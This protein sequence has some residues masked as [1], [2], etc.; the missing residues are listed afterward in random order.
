[1]PTGVGLH[2]D[3]MA[4]RPPT[5]RRRARPGSLERPVNAR[6]YRGT[7]LVLSIPL[8]LAAF[9]VARPAP[10]PPAFPPAFD[11]A[12]AATLAEELARFHPMR[13]PGSTGATAAST[14]YRSQLQPYGL[15]VRAQP[16]TADVPGSG[17]LRFENLIATVRGRSDRRIV[18]LAHR[19]NLGIGPGAN[20]NASGTAALIVLARS[21][22]A[23][24]TSEDQQPGPAHT[25]AFVSTD[26]GALGGY[27]ARH[28]AE[29][30][31]A[32]VD[33]VINLDAIAG[34]G[35]PRLVLAG[36]RPR[37][38]ALA[39][40]R[41]ASAR[42][43][44]QTGR[45]PT[46]PSAAG[47]LIDLAFPFSLYEQAPFVGRDVSALTITTQGETP[48]PAELDT[49]VRLR[50]LLRGPRLGQLGRS[51]QTLIGSIDQG[52]EVT[53]PGP[54]Y[55]YFGTRAVRG[56]AVQLVLVAALLPFLA[57][58]V[59]LFA[60]CRRRRIPLRPAVR[61]YVS[62]LAFWLFV[63]VVFAIVAR[64][65]GWP[66][67]EPVPLPPELDTSSPWPVAAIIVLV[68]SGGGAWVVA[69]DRL[70]PRRGISLEEELAGYTAAL[71]ILG[72][73]SLLV[74]AVNAFA[75][76]FV[77]PSL[78]AWL[79]LPQ[80][81]SRPIWTR[82]ALL[83]AGFTGPALLVWWLA[84]RL[85]LGFDALAYVVEL[86]ATGYVPVPLLVLFL[87]WLGVAGQLAALA[88]RRYAPYPS[89]KERAPRGPI[90][91]L[92]RVGLLAIERRRAASA[93]DR[94]LE[95]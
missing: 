86:V 50:E 87:A 91:R 10:L 79:W 81:Q 47:Q 40:V 11:T 76:L 38:P 95:G 58:A 21:F 44:E 57:A 84:Q 28:F 9:S 29:T 20:D 22:A 34:P 90:R 5:T 64:L 75:L 59:D 62:R 88:A 65:G 25:L 16:F 4:A 46:R 53:R 12:S 82:L 43:A 68:L 67:G 71:L 74:V 89:A 42:I 2:S 35:P 92:V 41:T 45:A 13:F 56:W 8:L 80:F 60:R 85:G 69:R 94:A 36:D 1:M 17:R 30:E 19:D 49:E 14:W 61:S 63:G 83:A 51:A 24:V 6:M 26:G 31:G 37:S 78:H 18:V 33:A 72:L 70:I 15:T 3:A 54:P 77:L 23:P 32:N 52:L 27:G 39:H 93:E 7:W 73:I 66:Q 55:L 48:L